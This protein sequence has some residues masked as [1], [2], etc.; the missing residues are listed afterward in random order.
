LVALKYG[1]MADC[2]S[3]LN[4]ADDACLMADKAASVSD[5]AYTLIILQKKREC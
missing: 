2:L 5:D 4:K 1:A 3:N